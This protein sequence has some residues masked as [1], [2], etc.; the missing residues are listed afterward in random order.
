MRTYVLII[1]IFMAYK[2]KIKEKSNWLKYY[3]R[4]PFTRIAK[5]IKRKD[6]SSTITGSDIWKLAK[7]QKLICPLSGRKITNKNISPDH[8]IHL[9]NGGNSK[10]NN[11]RLVVRE[12]NLARHTMNDQQFIKMCEDIFKFSQP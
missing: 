11:L 6:K 4:H 7:K 8:I 2:D 1:F 9:T 12:A 5:S 10:I 3:W